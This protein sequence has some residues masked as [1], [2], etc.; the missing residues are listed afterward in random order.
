MTE[1]FSKLLFFDFSMIYII[2]CSSRR[3]SN[4]IGGGYLTNETSELKYS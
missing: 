1:F 2:S 4:Q 3:G